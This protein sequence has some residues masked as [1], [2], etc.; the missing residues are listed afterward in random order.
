MKNSLSSNQWNA[1]DAAKRDA[2]PYLKYII[3]EYAIHDIN[4]LFHHFRAHHDHNLVMT[5]PDVTVSANRY[6]HAREKTQCANNIN[7]WSP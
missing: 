3:S 1:N 4:A 2:I 7:V 6:D 5:V